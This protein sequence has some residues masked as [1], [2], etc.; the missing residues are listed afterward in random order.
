[1]VDAL[2]AGQAD[3]GVLRACLLE[4]LQRAGQV[5]PGEF[6]VLSPQ[7]HAGE[8]C[9]R[10]SPIYPGWAFAA[11]RCHTAGLVPCPCCWRCWPCRT[12]MM[13]P[14]GACLPITIQCTTCCANYRFRLMT[15][16][17]S[18]GWKPGAPLLAMG[19]RCS[20]AAA[21]LAGLYRAGGSAGQRRTRE[22]S[23]A[24]TARDQL[25]ERIH[26]TNEKW[27]ICRGCRCWVNYLAHWRM[28]E[29]AAGHHRQLRAQP[30]APSIMASWTRPR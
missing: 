18:T 9:R 23:A 5:R 10:S 2:R 3:A 13:S 29:P 22:L 19:C 4:A 21:G 12:P 26:A 16:C 11:A 25:A 8:P 30:E 20:G 1:M 7:H 24:L 6:R 15:S 27:T 17:V 14:A 28:A